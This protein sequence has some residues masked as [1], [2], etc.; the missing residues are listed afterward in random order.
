MMS[1]P[2]AARQVATL[3]ELTEIP[4]GFSESQFITSLVSHWKSK[5]RDDRLPARSDFPAE[6]LK[7]WMGC[8]TLVDVVRDPMRF[9][10]RL[11]GTTVTEHMG[12]DSGGKWFEDL[13]DAPTLAKHVSAYRTAVERGGPAYFRGNLQYVNKDYRYFNSVHL[14]LAEDGTTVDML[15]LGMDFD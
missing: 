7:P 4:H 5:R 13:Y 9:R 12:R 15:M 3:L 8:I 6:S 14:P 11:I 10:W 2:L 1:T